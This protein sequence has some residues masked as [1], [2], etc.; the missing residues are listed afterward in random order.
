MQ[1]EDS[2]ARQQGAAAGLYP[3]PDVPILH[4][5]VFSNDPFEFEACV[6]FCNVLRP[7]TAYL[8]YSHPPSIYA[9]RTLCR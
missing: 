4:P 7:E 9:G 2:L 8:I 5:N 1:F 3:Q 6:T